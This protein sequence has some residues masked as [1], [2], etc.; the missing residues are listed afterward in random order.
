ME[1][2]RLLQTKW[3]CVVLGAGPAGSVAATLL[4]R[5]GLAVLLC[6]RSAFP[7]Y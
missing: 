4:A 6:E 2:E 1:T 5:H 3:D 7:R